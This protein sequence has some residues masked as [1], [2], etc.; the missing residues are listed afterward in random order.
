MKKFWLPL[1][2]SALLLSPLA[3]C[4]VSEGEEDTNTTTDTTTDTTV[5]ET[6]A[7]DT[8]TD[9]TVAT[10]YFAIFVE[11][12]WDGVCGLSGAPGADIDAIGLFDPTNDAANPELVG[13][14]DVVDFEQNPGGDTKCDNLDARYQMA[15]NAKGD[16]DATL[17]EGF[18]ALYEGFLIGEFENQAQV[19]PGYEVTVYEVDRDTCD[20]NGNCGNPETY[21]TYVATELDCVNQGTD[22]RSTCMVLISDEATGQAT[23]PLAGF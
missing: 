1:A 23:I 13:Y 18:I 2:L 12:D 21:A 7:T 16:P 15:D 6:G 17:Y 5:T 9:T 20:N 8:V 3:A 10:Q 11:D 19:L 4:E 22:F 14:L